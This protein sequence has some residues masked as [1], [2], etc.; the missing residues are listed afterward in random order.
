MNKT[1]EYSEILE[2]GDIND[3]VIETVGQIG[4]NKAFEV[5]Y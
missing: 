4:Q 1:I 5:G 3:R 2:F